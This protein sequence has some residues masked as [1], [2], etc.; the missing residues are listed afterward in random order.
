MKKLFAI[1]LLTILSTCLNFYYLGGGKM[2]MKKNTKNLRSLFSVFAVL[3]LAITALWWGANTS[4]INAQAVR[5]TLFDFT[6][7]GRTSFTVLTIPPAGST[8]NVIWKVAGNP[9]IQATDAPRLPSIAAAFGIRSIL[10]TINF[11]LCSSVTLR[12]NLF[13][14]TLMRT[15]KPTL[16]FTEMEFGICCVRRLVLR[17]CSLVT[18]RI[19][20]LSEIMTAMQKPTKLFS[21]TVFGMS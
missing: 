5:G 8:D 11:K 9:A 14:L 13:R 19:N 6:G 15:A 7:T 4:T 16:P 18:L 17:Q 2:F 20:L 12:I 1:T 3:G 21:E 10:L